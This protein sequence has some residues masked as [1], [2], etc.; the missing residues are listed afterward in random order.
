MQ[1]MSEETS[2]QG[3]TFFKINVRLPPVIIIL[4]F[5]SGMYMEQAVYYKLK[6]ITSINHMLCNIIITFKQADLK[7]WNTW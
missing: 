5:H 6:I 4:N 7:L 2:K 3:Q 1:Y